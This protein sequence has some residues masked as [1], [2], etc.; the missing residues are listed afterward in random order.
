MH[1]MQTKV[2]DAFA[3]RWIFT[4][5]NA[6]NACLLHEEFQKPLSSLPVQTPG[7]VDKIM[8]DKI[9]QHAGIMPRDYIVEVKN[10]HI[11][12]GSGWG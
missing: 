8:R 9:C 12:P 11:E 1:Q 7:R 4:Y 2:K 6:K 10:V 3:L 5:G